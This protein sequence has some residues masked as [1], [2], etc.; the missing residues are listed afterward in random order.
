MNDEI[1]NKISNMLPPELEEAKKFIELLIDTKP[2]KRETNLEY[3]ENIVPICCPVSAKHHFKKNGHQN[4]SQR[5]WCYDCGTSYTITNKSIIE[6]SILNYYQIKNLLQMMYEFK[7]LF[8]ISQELNINESTVF[9]SQIRI[10]DSLEQ[11]NSK[12]KLSGIVQVDEKYIRINFKGTPTDKMPRPSRKNGST[13]LT[14]GISNDQICVIVAL[15]SNGNLLIK[16][17]GNGNASTN[18]ISS[19]LKDK[20]EPGSIIVTDSKNSYDK[21]AKTNN[22][23]L[24]K[25]PSGMHKIDGYTI[26]GVN[27]IMS[28]IE[29]YLYRKR[30]I[31]SRHLQHHMNFI[32]YRK[33][34]K[35]AIEYL[36]INEKM[37]VD[38]ISLKIRLKSN[39]VYNTPMPFDV[40]EYKKWY[41]EH[42]DQ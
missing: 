25:I 40:D 41:K 24:I 15:D 23:K 39:D 27:E 6:H 33:I 22:F 3:L 5:I 19:A 35:A 20:I 11:V 18:M 37:Y 9:E 10:F 4:L 16:V 7:P 31:S 30:G 21:F 26:N 14:S 34:L 17:A 8:E 12:T 28:E 13:N 38:T 42:H 29:I 2:V 32:Q 36:D 1:K